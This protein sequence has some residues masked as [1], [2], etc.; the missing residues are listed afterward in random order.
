MQEAEK[1]KLRVCVHLG[2]RPQG[3]KRGLREV[4][5]KADTV[6]VGRCGSWWKKKKRGPGRA[7]SLD[8]RT[9]IRSFLT[10]QRFIFVLISESR[11]VEG[12]LFLFYFYFSAIIISLKKSDSP[13]K[14]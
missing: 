11:E 9:V 3:K 7:D 13:Q 2:V 1:F 5:I 12:W 8:T 4:L 10:H 14:Q 6:G